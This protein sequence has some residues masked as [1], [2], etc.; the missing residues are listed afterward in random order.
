MLISTKRSYQQGE[1]CLFG[2]FSPPIDGIHFQRLTLV[3]PCNSHR[4]SDSKPGRVPNCCVFVPKNTGTGTG[5]GSLQQQSEVLAPICEPQCLHLI[6]SA[7]TFSL[8]Y[9]PVPSWPGCSGI[10]LLWQCLHLIASGSMS[11]LQYGHSP[12]SA[13]GTGNSVTKRGDTQ[14]TKSCVN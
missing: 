10:I 4:P 11:Y 13:A 12:C 6:A 7:L 8:Q 9:R 14:S 5:S 3:Y 2:I 1:A